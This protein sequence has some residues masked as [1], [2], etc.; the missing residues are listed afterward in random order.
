MLPGGYIG[1]HVGYAYARTVDTAQGTTVD[2]SLFTPSTAA[3]APRRAGAGGRSHGELA[4][5]GLKPMLPTYTLPG[6]STTLSLQG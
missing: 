3:I 6:Q 4:K 2:H 1:E 5:G